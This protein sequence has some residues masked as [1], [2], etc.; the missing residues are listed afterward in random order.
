MRLNR[1]TTALSCAALSLCLMGGVARAAFFGQ[2]GPLGASSEHGL[3]MLGAY[4]GFG[5]NDMGATGQARIGLGNMD[6]DF[7]VE[8][9]FDKVSN[10]GP[11]G[12]GGQADVKLAL[13]QPSK[14][15]KNLKI[16]GDVSVGFNHYTGVTGL[17]VSAVPE[18]SWTSEP[19][20]SQQFGV[21]AGVGLAI[22]H[23]STS[24]VT[25]PDGTVV[26]GASATNTG[27]IF[28]GGA[29]FNI[30]SN[31]GLAAEVDTHFQSGG[32]TTEFMAGINFFGV[33]KKK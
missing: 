22:D 24:D 16:G 14:S 7:G 33:A 1:F 28:R 3:E 18:I 20:S 27:G 9:G 17:D 5:T 30:N 29:D 26:S 10:G 21:W 32:S 25:L 4:A 12:F 31:L 11:T 19:K 15:D 23:T 8:F 6:R 13:V 2:M